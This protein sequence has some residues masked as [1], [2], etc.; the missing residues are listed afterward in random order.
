MAE[1][2][3]YM[4]SIR[5]ISEGAILAMQQ[6]QRGLQVDDALACN[7]PS[8][9]NSREA[10]PADGAHTEKRQTVIVS[11]STLVEALVR[12]GQPLD[13]VR[14]QPITSFAEHFGVELIEPL[15]AFV[16]LVLIFGIVFLQ[17]DWRPHALRR[18]GPSWLFLVLGGGFVRVAAACSGQ[19]P[20][21]ALKIGARRKPSADRSEGINGCALR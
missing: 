19:W 3:T 12:D 5:W 2:L 20:A 7:A 4:L 21:R 18:M 1:G 14:Q 6:S 10:A 8:L 15:L 17:T 9:A 11:A 16:D 13:L